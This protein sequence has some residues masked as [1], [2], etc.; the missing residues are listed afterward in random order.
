MN[1]NEK[2][3]GFLNQY[4]FSLRI[5]KKTTLKKVSSCLSFLIILLEKLNYVKTIL[6]IAFWIHDQ[7]LTVSLSGQSWL[8]ALI[9]LI[10]NSSRYNIPNW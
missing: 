9:Y 1:F 7:S 2:T 8:H 4:C 6:S 3:K 5:V 10:N